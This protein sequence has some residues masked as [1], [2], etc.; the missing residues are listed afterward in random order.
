MLASAG[1]NTDLLSPVPVL[2]MPNVY[3]DVPDND[4]AEMISAVEGSVN[5]CD[6]DAG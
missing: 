5:V 2:S 4:I 3:V 1:V 6:E